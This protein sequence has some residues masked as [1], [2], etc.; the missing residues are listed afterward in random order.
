MIGLGGGGPGLAA[1]LVASRGK[2]IIVLANLDP[3]ITTHL[4]ERLGEALR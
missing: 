3:P 2:V 1:E 4:A